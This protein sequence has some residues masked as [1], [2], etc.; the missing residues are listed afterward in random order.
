MPAPFSPDPADSSSV[1][2]R[3]PD[4][5]PTPHDPNTTPLAGPSPPAHEPPT[6]ITAR[7]RPTV[8]PNLGES[9]AGRRL[10]H[11][12][13]IET[14]GAGGMAAV[15][16]ARD[17]DLGRVVALKILPP[18][19][20]A[21]P[22]NVVRFKQEA[23]AAARLDHDNVARVY[24]FGE[25]Q[26]LHF[27]AF[28]YVEGDNLRQLM[29]AHG[30]PIPVPEAVSV[31]LQVTAGLQHAAERGVVHRDIKPSNI[32]VTPDGRAKIVDMGLARSLDPKLA[33]QL[34]EAGVTLGTFDYISPEQAHDPRA[35]D[36]RSDIYSLGCTFYH[37]LTGRPPVP[38]GTAAAKLEAQRTQ[39]PSDPRDF[40]PAI[41]PDLVAILARMMAK[42]PDR[43][44]QDPAHLAAHLRALARKL[45][46]PA[47]P[48]SGTTPAA[49]PLHP[50]RRLS[51]PWAVT[52]LAICA[53]VI[54]MLINVFRWPKPADT[55]G[56]D[57]KGPGRVVGPHAPADPGVAAAGPREAADVAQLMALLREGATHIRLTGK[58]EYD[59]VRYRD[60]KGEQVEALL[61]GEDVELDG[62]PGLTTMR[63]GFA[64]D[65][66]A[67]SKTLTL[68][69]TGEGRGSAIVRGI[70][71]FLPER[72]AEDEESGL[73][74]SGF[75]RVTVE[76]CTFATRYQP[77][78]GPAALSVVLRGGLAVLAK[79]YFAPGCVGL[80]VDGP[81][82][83][84]ATD[85]ALGP[86]NAGVRVGRTAEAAGETELSLT[87]CSALLPN[88]GALVEVADQVPCVI[89]A[90]LCLF[91]G[92]GQFA[93]TDELPSVLRQ[94][95]ERAA[96]TRYDAARADGRVL[97]NG[98][99]NVAA[100]ADG[101]GTYLFADAAA[102]R[103]P[104]HDTETAIKHPWADRDP[105]ELLDPQKSPT[106]TDAKKAVKAFAP[107][108]KQRALRIEGDSNGVLGSRFVGPEPLL[109]DM[110]PAPESDPRDATI[111]VWDP[112]LPESSEEPGIYPTLERA[113]AAAK[114]GDTILIRYNGRLQVD[115]IELTKEGTHLTIKP[116]ADYKPVLVPAP[117]VLKKFAGLFKLYAGSSGGKLVLDGLQF[118]L[119]PDRTPA[120]AVLPGGG[121]LELR[122]CVITLEDGGEDLSAVTL[123]EPKNEMLMSGGP[124]RW[125]VPKV[126]FENT[127]VRGRGHLLAVKG[128]RPFELDV[129]NS[130]AALDA[131][132]ID[133]EPSTADP[134]GA[135][136]GVVRLSRVTT[137]LSAGLVHVRAAA[138][139]KPEAGPGLARTEVQAANCLFVPVNGTAGE[140]EPLVRADRLTDRGQLEQWFGWRGEENV[141]GY[142]RKKAV[143]EYRPTDAMPPLRLTGEQWLELTAEKDKPDRFASVKFPTRKAASLAATRPS[144]F[145]KRVQFEPPRPKESAEVGAAA[146]IPVPHD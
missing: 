76:G 43:R 77:Q 132:A 74:I 67:R 114:K 30:G 96:A 24:F 52:A 55:N 4:P 75:D 27:I 122:N 141:Y 103:W 86:Q 112:S 39:T 110:L 107:D 99:H 13:L 5:V 140:P 28:E 6:V 126:T 18:D 104:V 145:V 21:D 106:A 71:F 146:D 60:Q 36:V 129:R 66:K 118:R 90:G 9:L 94:R 26:G 89:R 1:R 97:P 128:S 12:E 80:F 3:T 100:Y 81:G 22:E 16:K 42:D 34:T 125:P 83:V 127:F 79:C 53:V 7:T 2:R 48:L 95:R 65:G 37:A 19:L 56:P 138:D 14:V 84:A 49:D 45:G 120:V 44:Y 119:P 130:V 93:P 54:A 46:I 51:L 69:G 85:C 101:E 91:A 135:G 92:P 124:D 82:R 31:L 111:K 50:R 73:L 88:G 35:A 32:V 15:L 108:L 17:L 23:R 102:G 58:E 123:V 105:F 70:R 61:T 87:H 8:D 40:N 133:V 38:D 47:G 78:R 98:Y 137:Y 64:P 143:L 25:D 11:F 131:P 116:D 59:L 117:S 139:R 72:D 113:V 20:A 142:D 62:I 63:L 134:S 10:G 121:Q 41:P 144:A 68:R 33:T 29:D 57:P 115:P 109:P 136:S